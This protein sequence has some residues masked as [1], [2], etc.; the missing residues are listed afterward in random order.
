MPAT[1]I[2]KAKQRQGPWVA[3]IGLFVDAPIL[4]GS[5]VRALI[6]N[7]P[8]KPEAIAVCLDAVFAAIPYCIDLLGGPRLDTNPSICRAFRPAA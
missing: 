3:T 6:V 5:R 7:L 2:D 1:S 4:A 8:G